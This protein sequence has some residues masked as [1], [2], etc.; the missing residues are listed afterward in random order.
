MNGK[1]HLI[2]GAV[3]AAGIINFIDFDI[4]I[5]VGIL[6]GSLLPDVDAEHSTINRL[7]PPLS[8]VYKK[9][10]KLSFSTRGNLYLWTRHRGALMHSIWTLVA[11]FALSM[12]TPSQI[13]IGMYGLALGVFS[14]HLLD[15]L[16]PQG[17]RWLYPKKINFIT[18]PKCLYK[19]LK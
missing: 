16:T 1:T 8:F 18:L 10:H 7:C 6:I 15:M 5:T 3:L 13:K 12:I 17:L 2:A 11:I 19:V 14:H 4:G 9:F